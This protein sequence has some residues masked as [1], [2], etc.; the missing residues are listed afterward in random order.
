MG[1]IVG[2]LCCVTAFSS[3]FLLFLIETQISTVR[4]NKIK[5]AKILSWWESNPGVVTVKLIIFIILKFNNSGWIRVVKKII[6]PFDSSRQDAQ[7][8]R[9]LFWI[10]WVKCRF[11]ILKSTFYA[12]I[13]NFVWMRLWTFSRGAEWFFIFIITT[14]NKREKAKTKMIDWWLMMMMMIDNFERD[15]IF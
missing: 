10:K 7:T 2:F 5:N 14:W 1:D 3:D 9:E 6:T 12:K 11:R 15:T 8:N 13:Y 4:C